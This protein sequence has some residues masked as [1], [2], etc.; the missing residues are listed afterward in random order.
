MFAEFC[1]LHENVDGHRS[2]LVQ[3]AIIP[4]KH[5][6][7]GGM[8][9][10]KPTQSQPEKL[11]SPAL[12]SKPAASYIIAVV[13]CNPSGLTHGTRHKPR[14]IFRVLHQPPVKDS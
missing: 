7:E 11:A 14:C 10:W 12:Q 8:L 1:W 5:E 9:G 6:D 4:N 2:I 3:Q 13:Q